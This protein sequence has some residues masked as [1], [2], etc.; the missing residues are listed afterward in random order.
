MGIALQQEA[1]RCWL[2]WEDGRQIMA[3]CQPDYSGGYYVFVDR[4][5]MPGDIEY[6]YTS[7]LRLTSNFDYQYL[8]IVVLKS[9]VDFTDP[10]QGPFRA[11]QHKNPF[12]LSGD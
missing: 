5:D 9:R 2:I 3:R 4:C 1:E 8:V 7:E 12:V 10:P 6:I 11:R